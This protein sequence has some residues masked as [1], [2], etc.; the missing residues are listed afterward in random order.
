LLRGCKATWDLEDFISV[1]KKM[2]RDDIKSFDVPGLALFWMGNEHYP[3]RLLS[4][5]INKSSATPYLILTVNFD[6]LQDLWDENCEAAPNSREGSVIEEDVEEEVVSSPRNDIDD[7]DS[8]VAS[9]SLVGKICEPRQLDSSGES[10]DD[11]PSE[12]KAPAPPAQKRHAVAKQRASKDAKHQKTAPPRPLVQ[13]KITEME[14]RKKRAA[15][16]ATQSTEPA[17]TSSLEELTI[18]EDASSGSDGIPR[19]IG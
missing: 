12:G 17:K 15:L 7:A 16:E 11:E 10:S 6:V 19:V 4:N 13:T 2:I 9:T 14:E 3:V 5:L 8:L 18:L 1:L